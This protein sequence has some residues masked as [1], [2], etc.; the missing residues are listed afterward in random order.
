MLL[1]LAMLTLIL[2]GC[3]LRQALPSTR[4]VGLT[5]T[6]EPTALA[7]VPPNNAGVNGYDLKAGNCVDAADEAIDLITKA[8]AGSYGGTPFTMDMH[9]S[10]DPVGV[11][12]NDPSSGCAATGKV[13]SFYRRQAVAVVQLNVYVLTTLWASVQPVVRRQWLEN[14]LNVLV[15]RYPKANVTINVFSNNTPCGSALVSFGSNTGRQIND[16]CN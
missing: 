15:E 8:G 5:P 6:P 1:P 3:T 12:P 11:K 10:L 14:V 7:T 16:G 13:L 4:L 9:L 2:S